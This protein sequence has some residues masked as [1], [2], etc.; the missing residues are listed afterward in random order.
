M[1][2]LFGAVNTDHIG[3]TGLTAWSSKVSVA[4]RFRLAAVN[5]ADRRLMVP[6]AGVPLLFD[7]SPVATNSARLLYQDSASAYQAANWTSGFTAGS[8]HTLVGVIDLTLGSNNIKLY[9][10]TDA[11]PK[12][13]ATSTLDPLDAGTA[14]DLGGHAGDADSLDGT[15]YELAYWPSVALTG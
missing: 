6:G 2:Y 9:A 12:A 4:A 8:L 10:D 1:A 13:Q 5:S 14:Y 11:T 7:F 15:L 3:V